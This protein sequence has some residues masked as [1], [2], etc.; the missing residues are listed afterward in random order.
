MATGT[1]RDFI[2]IVTDPNHPRYRQCARIDIYDWKESGNFFVTFPNGESDTFNAA[3]LREKNNVG[4]S[5]YAF[6]DARGKREDQKGFGP[7]NLQRTASEHGISL[8]QLAEYYRVLL[9][10]ELPRF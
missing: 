3:D 1:I 5:F 7:R 10:A 6:D 8:D 2:M 9:K 4:Y